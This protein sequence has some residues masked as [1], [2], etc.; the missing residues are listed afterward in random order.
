MYRRGDGTLAYFFSIEDMTAK[1]EAAGFAVL[2]CE[3]VTVINTNRKK[4]LQLRRV[5]IH[6]L[7]QRK[8]D[9][10]Q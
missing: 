9:E 2:E 5:F 7:A 6:L 4:G 8:C 1:A 10:P 3:Y